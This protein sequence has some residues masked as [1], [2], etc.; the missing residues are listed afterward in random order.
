[1]SETSIY[2]FEN[3]WQIQ[4]LSDGIRAIRRILEGGEGRGEP[5]YYEGDK[6]GPNPPVKMEMKRK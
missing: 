6:L 2:P 3:Q 1:M 5:T 4:D